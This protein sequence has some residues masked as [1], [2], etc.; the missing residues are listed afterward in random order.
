MSQYKTS[1]QIDRETH[2]YLFKAKKR[3]GE[4]FNQALRRELGL[5]DPSED[6]DEAEAEAPAQ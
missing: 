1:I 5:G 2:Q 6:G 4:S 3:P